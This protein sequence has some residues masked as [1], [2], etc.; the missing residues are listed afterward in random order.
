MRREEKARTG[1]GGGDA[2]LSWRPK[3]AIAA[4]SGISI[5]RRV[6]IKHE[7]PSIG[8]EGGHDLEMK[9]Q[10]GA[11]GRVTAP[12]GRENWNEAAVS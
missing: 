11:S 3:C 2:P 9:G 8:L 5:H 10:R 4:T 12:A 6:M 7:Q 1:T